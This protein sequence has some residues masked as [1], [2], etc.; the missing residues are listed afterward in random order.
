VQ[1]KFDIELAVENVAKHVRRMLSIGSCGW[2]L[3]WITCCY[4]NLT[5]KSWLC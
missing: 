4:E 5:E 3:F 1:G 2:L